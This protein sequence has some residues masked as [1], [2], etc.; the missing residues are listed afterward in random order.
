[1]FCCSRP[2]RSRGKPIAIIT[3][4]STNTNIISMRLNPLRPMCPPFDRPYL[5]VPCL[6]VSAS[7]ADTYVAIAPRKPQQNTAVM[8][9]FASP[10]RLGDPVTVDLVKQRAQAH[11]VLLRGI[12]SVAFSRPQ[13][14]GVCLAFRDR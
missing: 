6:H 3:P 10:G 2:L 4:A 7:T 9:V 14:A 8:Q 1:M 5:H 11:A 13:S 12:V